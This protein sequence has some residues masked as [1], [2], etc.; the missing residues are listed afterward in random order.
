MCVYLCMK[1]RGRRILETSW[2]QEQSYKIKNF[3]VVANSVYLIV[4]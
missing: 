3:L 2:K 4:R 1:E